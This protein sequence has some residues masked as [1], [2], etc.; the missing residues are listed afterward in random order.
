[1]SGYGIG[2]VVTGLLAFWPVVSQAQTD[3]DSLRAGL[4]AALELID[5][6]DL[7]EGHDAILALVDEHG[8]EDYLLLQT[9]RIKELLKMSAFWATHERPQAKDLIAGD[10]ESYNTRSGKIKVAYSRDSDAAVV[11][12]GDDGSARSFR[13]FLDL[14]GIG[15]TLEATDFRWVNGVPMHPI[16]FDGGYSVEISGRITDRKASLG[17][18]TQ[19]RWL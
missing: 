5:G 8:D 3:E 18:G 19:T 17:R 13:E 11:K 1:M 6:G 7:K 12:K 9:H 10:L 2:I 15:S 14:L 16:V 4:A